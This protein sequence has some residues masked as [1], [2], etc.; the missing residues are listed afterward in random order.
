MAAVFAKPKAV[1]EAPGMELLPREVFA[2][3]GKKEF[4][5]DPCE[6]VDALLLVDSFSDLENPPGFGLV[7]RFTSA[8][9]PGE[10]LTRNLQKGELSGR[11]IYRSRGRDPAILWA[12]GWDWERPGYAAS[13]SSSH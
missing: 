12:Q 10:K 5:F 11:P 13:P 8:Q 9:Q 7:L 2:V 4:G 6:I 1:L 3:M